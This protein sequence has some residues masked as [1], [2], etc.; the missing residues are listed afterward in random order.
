MAAV[1]R[2]VGGWVDYR[3]CSS[4][5][6]GVQSSL[7]RPRNFGVSALGIARLFVLCC[8]Q[9]TFPI[10][11]ILF[12]DP[13]WGRDSRSVLKV[14]FCKGESHGHMT[15]ASLSHS[16]TVVAQ[17]KPWPLC[18]GPWALTPCLSDR[19]GVRVLDA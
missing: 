6:V 15:F 4:E 18:S 1:S 5:S 10:L 19:L 3:P 11:D 2:G 17:I 16:Q 12:P 13:L 14:T 7:R 8:A 9:G